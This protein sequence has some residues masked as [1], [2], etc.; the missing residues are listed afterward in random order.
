[1]NP[2]GIS[3]RIKK[4]PMTL[5]QMLYGALGVELDLAAAVWRNNHAYSEPASRGLFIS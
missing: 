2:V 5:G 3:A 4:M 1:M